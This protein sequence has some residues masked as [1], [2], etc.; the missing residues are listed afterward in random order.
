VT[1]T[2][3]ILL[4]LAYGELSYIEAC[5]VLNDDIARSRIICDE[6]AELELERQSLG[7]I[8][9]LAGIFKL[10]IPVGKVVGDRFDAV[11]DSMGKILDYF[12]DKQN[13]SVSL[14]CGRAG[15]DEYDFLV[16][17]LLLII[18]ERGFGKA[19]LIRPHS[20]YE[21]YAQ[22]VLAREAIDFVVFPS[23]GGYQIGATFYV[24][25]ATEFQFRATKRPVISSQ[26][27]LAPRLAKVL[28]HLGNVPPGG[29]LLDPFCGS[30]TILAEAILEGINC[31]GVDRDPNSI[32]NAQR[33]LAWVASNSG[34]KKLGSYELIVGDAT[35]LSRKLKDRRVDAIVTEPIL[36]PNLTSTPG[37]KAARSMIRNASATYSDF[38]YSARGVLKKGG[39]LVVVVPSIRTSEGKD[40]AV[41]LEDVETVGFNEFQPFKDSVIDYPTKVTT[42]ST[43]WVKRMVYIY[44]RA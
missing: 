22:D 33:N 25:D 2:K 28:V 32:H 35:D 26:I 37:L 41:A 42:G 6:I 17:N 5:S 36:L 31:I 40:V 15:K 27:A 9:K 11:A 18:R 24:S 16:S 13:F 20:G 3:R 30:G 39:R 7:K 19:N 8:Q 21:L 34:S 29:L 12:G 44:E 10:A 4:A 38:L 1:E 23:S 43:R 14:Y